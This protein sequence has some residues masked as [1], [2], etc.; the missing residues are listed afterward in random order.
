MCS[1]PTLA[2]IAPIITAVDA[3]NRSGIQAIVRDKASHAFILACT[4]GER[5]CMQYMKA[6]RVERSVEWTC[7]RCCPSLLCIILS[8]CSRILRK[9]T[10]LILAYSRHQCASSANCLSYSQEHQGHQSINVSAVHLQPKEAASGFAANPGWSA[11]TL[12]A[13]SLFSLV[14]ADRPASTDNLKWRARRPVCLR[15]VAV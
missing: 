6:D 2:M 12:T 10:A 5:M 13:C 11:F 7:R 8:C 14:P 1:R 9:A 15:C 4:K 3:W